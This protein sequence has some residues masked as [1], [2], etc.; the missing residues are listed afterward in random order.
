MNNSKAF[1]PAKKLAKDTHRHFSKDENRNCQQTQSFSFMKIILPE[2]LS[3]IKKRRRSFT[4][5]FTPQ[6]IVTTNARPGVRKPASG[7]PLWVAWVRYFPDALVVRSKW[8]AGDFNWCSDG[9]LV[10]QAAV[11]L[12]VSQHRLEKVSLLYINSVHIILS[13]NRVFNTK[14][15]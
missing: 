3:C 4:Y 11:Y 14:H 1:N 8:K 12:T 2:R 5:W 10:S 7:S 15:Q 9:M 13:V 6:M